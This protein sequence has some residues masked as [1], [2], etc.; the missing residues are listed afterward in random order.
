MR[1][2]MRPKVGGNSGKLDWKS[3]SKSVKN[4]EN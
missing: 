2:K 3:D 4:L 1:F